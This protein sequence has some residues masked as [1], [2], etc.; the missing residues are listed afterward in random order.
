MRDEVK[1]VGEVERAA[2]LCQT[3]AISVGDKTTVSNRF[4]ARAPPPQR[5]LL[6]EAEEMP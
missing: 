3:K 4:P 2:V 5:G 1:A 6:Q